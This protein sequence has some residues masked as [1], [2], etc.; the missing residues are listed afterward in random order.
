MNVREALRLLRERDETKLRELHEMI[1]AGID[2]LERGE[3]TEYDPANVKAL[4]VAAGDRGR[5]RLTRLRKTG[6]R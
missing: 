1:E 4:A 2:Q 5:R 6:T 3:Y